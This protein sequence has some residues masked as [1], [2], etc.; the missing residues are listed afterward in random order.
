MRCSTMQVLK[1]ICKIV[2]LGNK[3]QSKQH[4]AIDKNQPDTVVNL[5]SGFD[6][7]MCRI[8]NLRHA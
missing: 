2:Q 4:Q 1:T 3:M 7:F 6:V 5:N 8:K